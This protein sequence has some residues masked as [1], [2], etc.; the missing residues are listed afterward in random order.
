MKSYKIIILLVL[1]ICITITTCACG[2][3]DAKST[4]K[5]PARVFDVEIEGTS[6]PRI[7]GVEITYDSKARIDTVSYSV[8]GYD[9]KQEYSYDNE[10][11]VI[12]TI[13]KT[14][15]IEEKIIRYVDIPIESGFST[16]DG[17]YLKVTDDMSVKKER[18]SRDKGTENTDNKTSQ[19]E[20]PQ[21]NKDYSQYIG[22]WKP[23]NGEATTDYL[24][25][26]DVS[27]NHIVF[28]LG[29]NTYD[30]N[31]IVDTDYIEADI[32]LN[33]AF[34]FN[35]TDSWGNYGHGTIRL[36]NGIAHVSIVPEGYI[37]DVQSQFGIVAI[38]YDFVKISDVP[39]NPSLR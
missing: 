22:F 20:A 2:A 18:K 9:Y 36:K 33:D 27:G 21:N 38:D 26:K 3:A 30:A 28:F 12:K 34:D 29:Y 10:Q 8:D 11:I 19:T 39:G 1:V 37:G 6:E 17:Y 16:V 7:D 14:E 24:A 35:Y 23:E 25:I 4:Y 32:Q 15:V 5:P 31:Y 13:Y